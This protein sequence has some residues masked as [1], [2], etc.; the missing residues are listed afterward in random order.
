MLNFRDAD[1]APL[2]GTK[3]VPVLE[4]TST[5]EKGCIIS[6]KDDGPSVAFFVDKCLKTCSFIAAQLGLNAVLDYKSSGP[7]GGNKASKKNGRRAEI[8][9]E[10]AKDNRKSTRHAVDLRWPPAETYLHPLCTR[11]DS[12]LTHI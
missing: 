11:L 5:R 6:F 8:R 4:S 3:S 9:S 10:S 2:A 12:L 7:L 1:G